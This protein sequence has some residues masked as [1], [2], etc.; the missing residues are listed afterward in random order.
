MCAQ[1]FKG[2]SFGL[3]QGAGR[4]V[5]RKSYDNVDLIKRI[6]SWSIKCIVHFCADDV[7]KI[8]IISDDDEGQKPEQTPSD[9]PL[10]KRST[11]N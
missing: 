10:W 5:W 3:S 1:G 2:S 7:M 11:L 8:M 4:Y 6:L 9:Y